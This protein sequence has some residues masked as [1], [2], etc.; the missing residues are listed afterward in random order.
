MTTRFV[1]LRH[2][3]CAPTAERLLGRAL[4]SPLDERGAAEAQAAARRLQALRP[5][6]VETSPRLRTLQTAACVAEAAG[7]DLRVARALDEVDFGRWAGR[8]FAELEGD[9]QWRT[10]NA[11]RA[12]AHTPAGDSME[13]VRRRLC[14]HLERLAA[15][16]PDSTLVLVTHAEPIRAAVL[17]ARG[18]GA[19][20]WDD[21]QIAPASVTT[22]LFEHGRLVLAGV[23]ERVAA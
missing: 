18:L 4:D 7:C 3:T 2:G 10:W 20:R 8:R 11:H 21:V 5:R 19:D 14:E 6:R 22:L 23:N 15:V 16:D 1:L 9:P 13:D 17:H 12:T